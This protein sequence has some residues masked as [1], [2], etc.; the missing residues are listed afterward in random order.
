[1]LTGYG[2][3]KYGNVLEKIGRGAEISRKRRKEEH[4]NVQFQKEL[5]LDLH[6]SKKTVSSLRSENSL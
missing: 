2:T 4:R 6:Q 1:M 5:G 3:L